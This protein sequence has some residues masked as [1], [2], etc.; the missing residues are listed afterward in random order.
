MRR[1]TAAI[2]SAVFF[3]LAPGTTAGL[4]PWLITHWRLPEVG[5]AGR[6]LEVLGAVLVVVG[7][8]PL[9]HA[10]TRFVAAGGTPMPAAPTHHLVVTGFH[11]YLRNPM[12]AGVTLAILGQALI[13]GSVALVL[14]ASVFW[15]T[16]ATFVLLYEEP[17]LADQFGDE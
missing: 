15:A 16:T 1:T 17:T 3:V 9:V 12:Y 8:V 2:V 10:F 5:A 14:W 13:F 7:L 4:V 6:A 11:R